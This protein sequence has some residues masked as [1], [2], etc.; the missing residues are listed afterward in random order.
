MSV[1]LLSAH[2]QHRRRRRLAARRWTLAG[3]L[4]AALLAVAAVA[5]HGL[6]A[7]DDRSVKGEIDRV[8]RDSREIE[9]R[10]PDRAAA[11]ARVQ[12]DLV[13][14]DTVNAPP[15]YSRLLAALSAALADDG[16]LTS[17]KWDLAP[18]PTSN[19]VPLNADGK[20]LKSDAFAGPVRL[21]VQLTGLVR[22]QAA[23]TRVL[24]HLGQAGLFDEVRLVKSGR[25]AF[26]GDDVLSFQLACTTLGAAPAG[27]AP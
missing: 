15:D 16:M 9:T 23:I 20:P 27:A 12:A 11:L 26:K 2:Q 6:F 21:Q 5:L 4:Q 10:K 17:L 8:G 19:V 7:I 24:D 3:L 18:A 1:N 22:T 14:R 25:D 13:L